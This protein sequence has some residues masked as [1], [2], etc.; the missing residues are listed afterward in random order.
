MQS[1]IK[2]NPIIG[3]V[4]TGIGGVVGQVL[5]Q[6]LG[7][8]YGKSRVPYDNYPARLHEGEKVLTKQEANQYDNNKG[9]ASG[10]NIIIQGLTV[11]EEA[12]I[13]LIADR[14]V[15]KM[16]IAIAGGV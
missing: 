4:A 12:D 10:F 8:A 1:F 13:D 3:K 15:K 6:V 9:K 5:G 11:R 14:M 2:N 7:S 16:N